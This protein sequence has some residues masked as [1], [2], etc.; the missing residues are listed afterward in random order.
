MGIDSERRERDFVEY[1]GVIV[2][3]TE[4]AIGIATGV[5]SELEYWIPKSLIGRI[6]YADGGDARD[7]RKGEAIEALELDMWFAEKL[8]I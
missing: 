6:T 3:E 8:G 1:E 2:A 5:A 7:I 4:R